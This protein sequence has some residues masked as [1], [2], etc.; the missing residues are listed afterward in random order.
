MQRAMIAVHAALFRVWVRAAPEE[1]FHRRELALS[2]RRD[3]HRVESCG[4]VLARVLR[5]ECTHAL[6]ADPHGI[7]AQRFGHERR[8]QVQSLGLEALDAANVRPF[9]VKPELGIIERGRR[10][11][12]ILGLQL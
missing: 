4:R 3:E 8:E 2:R 1:Q 6:R 11:V 9:D 7:P 5:S 10:L 12:H